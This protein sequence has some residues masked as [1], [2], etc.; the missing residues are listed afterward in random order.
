MFFNPPES[1]IT[2]PELLTV[3]FLMLPIM[4]LLVEILQ[5]LPL[6]IL[7]G[8]LS[9]KSVMSVTNHAII[10]FMTILTLERKSLFTIIHKLNGH[11]LGI[12]VYWSINI[13]IIFIR[14]LQIASIFM[15]QEKGFKKSVETQIKALD[16]F[17]HSKVNKL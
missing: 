16:Q 2:L 4:I 1:L 7:L 11:P 17:S 3:F 8:F 13:L 10:Q 15:S 12:Q 5:F 6:I 9:L 14:E